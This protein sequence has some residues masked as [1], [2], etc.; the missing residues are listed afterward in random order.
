MTKLLTFGCSLTRYHWPTW[1]D[2]LGFHFDNF[3][4]WANRGAGNKQI[5]ERFSEAVLK[6]QLNS[7]DVIIIQW[8]DYHRFDRKYDDASMHE[9]WYQG[10]NLLLDTDIDPIKIFIARKL[11]DE[12]SYILHTWNYIHAAT[13][14]A[15]NLKC[16]VFMTS[17]I[18]LQQDLTGDLSIYQNVVKD[19]NWIDTNLYNWCIDNHKDKLTTFAGAGDWTNKSKIIQDQHPTPIMHYY[20][21][22]NSIA[23]LL[24]LNLDKQFAD[25]MQ[26]VVED[27]TDFYSIG[28]AIENAGYNTNQFYQRGY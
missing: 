27:T 5:F 21:L 28:Q 23:P 4:N 26:T 6:N 18:D 25:V 7:D 12:Q 22:E 8:T 2:I 16:K 11:W 19:G 14:I 24:G 9:S 10:G 15:K 20:W 1:A 3:Q 17:S 13:A